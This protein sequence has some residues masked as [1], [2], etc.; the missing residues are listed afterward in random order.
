MLGTRLAV[1]CPLPRLGLIVVDEEH[2][3][4]YKQQDGVRYHA[5]D[6]AVWRAQLR[7]VPIVLG[8][9][10]PSLESY[11]QVEARR[12][13]RL[14]LPERADPRATLPKIAF[15]PTRDPRAHDGLAGPLWDALAATLAREEQSLVFVN[16][17]GFAP[18]LKCAAC[19]WEAACTALQ[20]AAHAASRARGA[21]LPPLRPP[22]AR[23]GRVP[24]LRQRR[25]PAAG[26][27]DAAAR[28][29]AR[30]RFSARAHRAHRSRQHARARRVRRDARADRARRDRRDDRHADAGEGAR[31]PAPHARRR[32][33]R[34]QRA[35]QRGFPRDRADARAAD[36]G[37]RTRRACRACGE[38]SSCR[39]TFRRIRSTRRSRPPTTTPSRARCSTSGARRACRPRRTPRC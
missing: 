15:V 7:G 24:V 19:A 21:A 31:L 27:R 9:A 38:A 34:R 36:P 22:G 29:R 14:S 23:A 6:V 32:R 39:P 12:Y 20:R 11:A 18:S 16:R 17:R 26:L 30:R 33:R 4:S 28:A 35:L 13:R 1:F 8:S 5:R 10:T 25:P 2:D 37:R 3:D